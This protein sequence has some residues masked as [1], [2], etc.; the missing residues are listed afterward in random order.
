MM[1]WQRWCVISLV[2]LS[3]PIL[4][5]CGSGAGALFQTNPTPTPV[6][7]VREAAD[8]VAEGRI[9][10]RR[11][12]WLATAVAGDVAEILVAEGDQ[13]A[14]GQLLLRIADSQQRAAVA[15]AEAGLEMAKAQRA[16]IKA[17]PRAEEIASAEASIEAARAGVQSAAAAVAAAEAR[18]A[19]LQAGATAEELAIAEHQV[20]AARNALW[21]AQAQ[22]DG[23][24]GQPGVPAAN[25]DAAK[26]AV[27]QAEEALRIAE[28]QLQQLQKGAR[29]QDLDAAQAQV[30]QAQGELEAAKASQAQ[31]EAALA[32]LKKGATEEA[33]AVAEA[34]VSQAQAALARAQ[35]AL[36]DTEVRA[37]MAG[38][39]AQ[40]NI[41]AG[42]KVAAGTPAIQLADLSAWK[43]E[44]DDLTEMD[45]VHV[46]VGQAVRIIPDALPDLTIMGTVEAIETVY[47]EKRGD[48]TYT[49]H[50]R[51]DNP[52]P[53]LR[54]GM[55]VA[56]L[57]DS[58]EGNGKGG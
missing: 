10:P 4:A 21:S 45:I 20:E 16:Q 57:F 35:A 43:V 30:E 6:P 41:K 18:L 38:S 52:D 44:T 42:E 53:R 56:V 48:V 40:I 36:A 24:C 1:R 34:Q 13:V 9:V 15:E 8:V 26:G 12:V 11:W 29:Q 54:W 51:F 33:I 19:Q 27:Q 55:T 58:P 17:G 23:I 14:Q 25:C 37:P 49:V 5:G 32:L 50:I 39:V 31:A 28:L 46:S 22:R 47:E 7:I 3:A 2:F